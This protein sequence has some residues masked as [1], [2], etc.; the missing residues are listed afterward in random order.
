MVVLKLK[1]AE[2]FRAKKDLEA[3]RKKMDRYQEMIQ[4]QNEVAADLQGQMGI[5]RSKNSQLNER[6]FVIELQ[7]KNLEVQVQ[8]M[9]EVV[10]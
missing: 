9:K 1:T 10:K 3:A 4:E 7:K 6:H 5:L 2:M 8:E